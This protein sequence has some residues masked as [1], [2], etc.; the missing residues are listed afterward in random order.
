MN[1][2]QIE[3]FSSKQSDNWRTPIG[4]YN[5]LD[6]EFNFDFDPCPYMSEFD[7]LACDWGLRNYVNPPYSKITGFLKKAHHELYYKKAEV[8]VFLLFTNTDT[9]WFHNYLYNIAELR[10]IKGRLK[11]QNDETETNNSA[12]RPSMVCILRKENALPV[13]Y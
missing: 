2:Q 5:K 10:F 8:C 9:R 4:I 11:F 1:K 13:I 12:M 7:G 6:S 3:L